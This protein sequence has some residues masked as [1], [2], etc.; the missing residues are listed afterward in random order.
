MFHICALS[1]RLSY[2]YK[3]IAYESKVFY[4]VFRKIVTIHYF[5]NVVWV[6]FLVK[7]SENLARQVRIVTVNKYKCFSFLFWKKYYFIQVLKLHMLSDFFLCLRLIHKKI[8]I[9]TLLVRRNCWKILAC[10]LN[11][12]NTARFD[13]NEKIKLKLIRYTIMIMW[14]EK[15]SQ[16]T[17]P[18]FKTPCLLPYA[19]VKNYLKY[20]LFA[21]R[22]WLARSLTT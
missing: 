7:V 2:L 8:E 6:V 15:L 14:L 20:H 9:S 10:S 11:T 12:Q 22:R 19:S 17:V 18:F 16:A 4:L 5:S 13:Q 1:R 21:T 3:K